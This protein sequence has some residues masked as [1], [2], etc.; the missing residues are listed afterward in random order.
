MADQIVRKLSDADAIL[1]VGKDLAA[2]LLA[3]EVSGSTLD[4]WRKQDGGMKA[5]EAVRLRTA[6]GRQIF[7]ASV[8]RRQFSQLDC[9]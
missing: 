1:D 4:R 8:L 7:P 6:T 5:E 9:C 3:L 2:V